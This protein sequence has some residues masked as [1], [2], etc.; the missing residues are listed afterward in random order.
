MWC[1]KKSPICKAALVDDG[2]CRNHRPLGSLQGLDKQTKKALDSRAYSGKLETGDKALSALS[3]CGV[4]L[5]WIIE[6]FA[7]EIGPHLP[8]PTPTLF[9]ALSAPFH[10]HRCVLGILA[11]ILID[12]LLCVLHTS[13]LALVSS[14]SPVVSHGNFVGCTRLFFGLTLLYPELSCITYPCMYVSCI[15]AFNA[16]MPHVSPP[17]FAHTLHESPQTTL[18]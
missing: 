11:L 1:K 18:E 2:S 6:N 5:G 12:P 9:L 15:N 14:Q 3:A 16:H 13:P 7:L 4:N 17:F 10:I 8:C